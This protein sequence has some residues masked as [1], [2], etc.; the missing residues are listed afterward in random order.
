MGGGESFFQ[1]ACS[2][3]CFR[4]SILFVCSFFK[5]NEIMQIVELRNEHRGFPVFLSLFTGAPS[6]RLYTEKHSGIL[7]CR[8][9]LPL[10]QQ[11]S[12]FRPQL[13]AFCG[14]QDAAAAKQ[15]I[16]GGCGDK[17]MGVRQRSITARASG[18]DAPPRG[19]VGHRYDRPDSYNRTG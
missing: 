13:S 7:L 15:A 8:L 16:A 14:R 3:I 12:S 9:W 1:N 18:N 19:A 6:P 10:Q 17:T 4:L 5:R 11:C 2:P